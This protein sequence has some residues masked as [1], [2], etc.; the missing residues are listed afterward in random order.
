MIV[1]NEGARL[2]ACLASVS[3]VVDEVVVVDT[4][5]TDDT[6]SIA[7]RFGAKLSHFD[8]RVPDF[9]GARNLSIAQATGDWVFV[10]DADETLTA[11]ARAV[12]RALSRFGEP[13]AYVVQRR[14]LRPSPAAEVL[15]DYAVRLFPNDPKHRYRGRV[16]ETIDASILANDVRIRTSQLTIDHTLPQEDSRTLEKSRFYLGILDQELAVDPDDVDRLNF[17]RAELHKLGLL[18]E[19]ARTAE[20]IAALA[21]NDAVNHRTVGL[22]RL[23]QDGDLVGAERAFCRAL[24]LK[25]DDAQTLAYLRSLPRATG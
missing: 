20:R 6:L 18:D 7:S 13:A 12:L 23:I 25:P 17:R 1:K 11:G 9:A 4:G 16:H 15:V 14:N 8:F 10:L 19:A 21:P 24:E 3:E 5:S 22:Y 2:G